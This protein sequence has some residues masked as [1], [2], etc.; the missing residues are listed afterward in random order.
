MHVQ[1][2]GSFLDYANSLNFIDICR[3][4]ESLCKLYF[5]SLLSNNKNGSKQ[6]QGYLD[7]AIYIKTSHNIIFM[8]NIMGIF[9]KS[10]C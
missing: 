9:F 2:Y 1:F 4:A 8:T 3:L 6:F 7:D 5:K 10:K